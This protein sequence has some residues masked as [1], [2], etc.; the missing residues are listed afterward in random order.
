[1]AAVGQNASLRKL[2]LEVAR[3]R[4]GG[5]SPRKQ[6]LRGIAAL[7]NGSSI[8][9]A[10]KIDLFP[11]V[12][13]AFS[14][15]DAK[16]ELVPGECTAST[17]D[18]GSLE[19]VGYLCAERLPGIPIVAQFHRV[20]T[21]EQDCAEHKWLKV[22]PQH[23]GNGLSAALLLRSFDFYKEIGL[24]SVKLEA[25]ME[26]GKW[27]WARVGFDFK[28]QGQLERV[29][30]WALQVT[31]RLNVR[32]PGIDAFTSATQF[33]TMEGS[34]KISLA[35]IGT[36]PH[37]EIEKIA[38]QNCLEM[39]KPIRLGRAV[40]LTG[41]AWDGRL[42]LYGPSYEQFKVYADAKAEAAR[43]ALCGGET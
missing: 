34:R 8:D 6:L 14:I 21:L 16:L 1:M 2:E 31:E 35:E 18:G 26:T 9:L 5:E 13:E 43:Q 32:R 38:A 36:T 15:P 10:E 39:E 20:L 28:K 22:E 19:L 11:E 4:A 33:A 3:R 41:P 24:K 12:R 42:D 27:H 30:R 37:G 7:A 17:E 25:C 29:R 23:R 40:M